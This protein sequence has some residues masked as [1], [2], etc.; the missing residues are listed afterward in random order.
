ME[1]TEAGGQALPGWSGLLRQ[2][3]LSSR[4]GIG[5]LP[6]PR[7]PPSLFS[8]Y[9]SA[10]LLHPPPP[11][12][13]V[14][15]QVGLGGG[16]ERRHGL[17]PLIRRLRLGGGGE[18]EQTGEQRRRHAPRLAL[19]RLAELEAHEAVKDRLGSSPKT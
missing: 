10:L 11:P 15:E 18:P 2:L 5:S 6:S 13:R 12:R 7:K 9:P 8:G 17:Q 1:G 19:E 16:T 14:V 3:L 4:I